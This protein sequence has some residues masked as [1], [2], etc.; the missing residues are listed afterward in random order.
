MAE[1]L[2]EAVAE[3]RL[4]MEEF[5]ARLEAAYR[6]RTFAELEPLTADLPAAAAAAPADGARGAWAERVGGTP[7]SKWAVGIMG[8]FQRKGRWVAPRRFTAFSIWGG[9]QIDLREARFEDRE[10]VIR[11]FALMGGMSV[12]VPPE[13]ELDVRGVGIMG[14]FDQSKT[15]GG[16][17]GAPRVVVKGLAIWGGVG[18][19]RKRAKAE[20]QRLEAERAE[21]S[22][23]GKPSSTGRELDGGAREAGP[24]QR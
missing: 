10:V 15:G 16:E 20:R 7:S 6:A 12:V 8:G 24:E 2:R 21:R 3:G 22:L 9:G 19:I 1:A 23:D 17:P 14:G 11:C 4:D 13:I 5:D 18:T